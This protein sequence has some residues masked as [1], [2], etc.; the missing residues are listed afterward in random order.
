MSGKEVLIIEVDTSDNTQ[1][2]CGDAELI[3]VTKMP[4]NV[5]VFD[6]RVSSGMGRHRSVSSLVW[7]IMVI[8]MENFRIGLQLPDDAVGVFGIV[9]S[10]LGF[11]AG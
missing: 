4:I 2:I 5:K 8:G 3:G 7:V 9:F 6:I 1:V 11:D 10:N